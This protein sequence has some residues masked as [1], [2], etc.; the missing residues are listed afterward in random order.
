MVNLFKDGGTQNNG[1]VGTMIVLTQCFAAANMVVF[2]KQL[3]LKYDP[4]VTTLVFYSI[5][6]VFTILVF[7]VLS[8]QFSTKDLIFNGDRLPWIAVA[9]ASVFA[10]LFAYNAL[11][12]ANKRLSPSVTTVYNTIQPFGTVVLSYIILAITPTLPELLGGLI[13]A[14]GLIITVNG[15]CRLDN[16][17]YSMVYQI[18]SLYRG[19]AYCHKQRHLL[20]RLHESYL[21]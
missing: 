19:N 6:T 7:S 17:S 13:I 1:N 15:R 12:W 20:Q 5:G 18:V 11:S 14:V 2:Q 21:D 8:S 3:L 16:R 10:T 9:Y 4:A